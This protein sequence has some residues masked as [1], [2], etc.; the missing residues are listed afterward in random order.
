MYISNLGDVIGSIEAILDVLETYNSDKCKLDIIHYG[1]GNV[2]MTDIEY[3]STFN[4]KSELFSKV[5]ILKM[6]INITNVFHLYSSNSLC[7]QC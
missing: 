6:C 3:A 1:V 2:N 4:G 5:N 7:L